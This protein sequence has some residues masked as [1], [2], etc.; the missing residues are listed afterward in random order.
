MQTAILKAKKYSR[1]TKKFTYYL[2]VDAKDDLLVMAPLQL[3][4]NDVLKAGL[5]CEEREEIAFMAG[6]QYAQEAVDRLAK[7]KHDANTPKSKSIMPAQ[8]H[9][10]KLPK[11]F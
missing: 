5:T 2:E 1:E 8:I 4:N 9:Q 7:I 11:S 6:L 10:N 3:F